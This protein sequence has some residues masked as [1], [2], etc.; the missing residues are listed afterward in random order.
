[1]NFSAAHNLRGYRGKCE[2]LHGHNWKVEACLRGKALDKCGML[3]DFS[4]IKR[5]LAAVLDELDHRYLNG[6]AYFKK[7]NPTSENIAKYIFA[8][9]K[10]RLK[11]LCCVT[12]WESENSA[13][14]YYG[15]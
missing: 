4:G 13:A 9:L 10:P 11:G 12:V 8:R 1:M 15:K 3:A 14:T 2:A 5:Q 7:V 6:S